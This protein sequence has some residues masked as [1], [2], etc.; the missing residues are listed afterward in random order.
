MT[1]Q[2]RTM[3]LI[4]VITSL[5]AIV[6]SVY[7][8]IHTGVLGVAAVFSGVLIV[9]NVLMMHFARKHTRI[10]TFMNFRPTFPAT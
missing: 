2:Q 4:S 6:V 3:L 1:G 9:Q 10:N 7:A 5:L 8:A